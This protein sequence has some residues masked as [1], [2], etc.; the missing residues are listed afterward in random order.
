MT[1][2]RA[3]VT[4]ASRGI[5]RAI[6]VALAESGFDVAVAAR[7]VRPGD[8]TLEHS[9]SVQKKDT[10]PLPGSLEET[11]QAIEAAGRRALPL[12]MDLTDLGSVETAVGRLLDE[13][14]GADLVVNNGRHIGPGLMDGI[15]DTPIEQYPL[16]L[17]AH[18]VAPIRIAQL[19][20]PAMIEQGRA[21]FITISSAA[22]YD[23][24]PE[25][26][27]PGLG[28]RIGKAS[29][30]TLVGSLLAEHGD[31]GIRAFNVNPGFVL[32]ERNSL[33]AEEFGFD[34]AWAAP[35]AAIG[36]A[37][38]W[39]ATAAEADPLQR[40]NIDAQV[41]VREHGLFPDWAESGD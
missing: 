3:L 1:A 32:T 31:D 10:R 29:G 28:Y 6:A 13:W 19:L 39:L 5:G 30:H 16:F 34:P 33:D 23:F 4:G 14:G 22:G 35:P 38:V 37:I 11:A 15:I 12:R 17:M 36:A 25:G 21:T 41:L 2:P 27:R 7:T 9:Q 18:G 26:P 24:Y 40:E 8:P 20:L